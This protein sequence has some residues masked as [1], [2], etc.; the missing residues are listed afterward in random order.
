MRVIKYSHNNAD[1]KLDSKISSDIF[2]VINHYDIIYGE[3]VTRKL[4][5]DLI[6]K[7][8]KLGW[9]DKIE[10]QEGTHISITSY[11]DKHGMCIQTGNMSRFYADLL[12]LQH[13]YQ[14]GRIKGAYYLIPS[15][16]TSKKLGSNIANFER[17][18]L[19][20]ELFKSTITI[21][22]IIIGMD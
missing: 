8:E 2:Q 3:G 11:F 10:L 5:G 9:S 20:I 4:R 7:F 18:T 19:E 14:N 1:Q 12:K 17:L 6:E 16:E 22:I 15:K 21:P 13:L